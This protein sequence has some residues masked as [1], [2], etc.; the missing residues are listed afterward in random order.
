MKKDLFYRCLS[1]LAFFS[2]TLIFSY[3]KK[4]DPS[5]VF[6][7]QGN[8]GIE[9]GIVKT[10]D[11]ASVEIPPDALSTS[12]TISITYVTNNDI[13]INYGNKIYELKPDG[14]T[15]NDSII[16][17]LPFD[18]TYVDL[19]NNEDNYGIGIMVLQNNEWIKLKTNID[20]QNKIAY[21]KTN[22]FS[23]YLVFNPSKWSDYFIKN[24]NSESKVWDVPY[25]YQGAAEWCGYYS[26]S[27]AA[28]YAGYSIKGPQFAAKFN[29]PYDDG[30]TRL[31]NI[32][33]GLTLSQM[34]IS[35]EIAYPSWAN[36]TDLCGYIISILQTGNP[37]WLGIKDHDHAVII[38]G[39]NNTGFFVNDPS[40]HYLNQLPI[41]HPVNN[42]VLVPY[43]IFITSL[44]GPKNECTLT[45]T[46]SGSHSKKGITLNFQQGVSWLK[47]YNNS[48]NWIGKLFFDGTHNDDG[49]YLLNKITNEESFDGSDYVYICPN[50]GNSNLENSVDCNLNVLL[51]NKLK[52]GPIPLNI[53]AHTDY[54][55]ID[56]VTFQLSNL[57][58]GTHILT[59]VISSQNNSEVYDFW[60]FRINLANEFID[61]GQ[62]PNTPSLPNPGNR[63]S[64]VRT[65]TTLTWSCSDPDGD[66]LAYDVYF[67]TNENPLN[68]IISNSASTSI[69][70]SSLNQGV[71]YFWRVVARD[72]Q[73]NSTTGPVW[74]FTIGTT[75]VVDFTYSPNPVIAGQ[76]V[77]FTDRSSSN[78]TGWEWDFGDGSNTSN[79]QNPTHRF[80]SPGTYE[81]N[82][83][84]SNVFGWS[85]ASTRITV[86]ADVSVPVANFTA[87]QTTI[88]AGGTITFTDQSTNNPTSWSWNFDDGGNST[89]RNPF[90]TYSTAGTYTVTLTATNSAGSDIETNNIT[91]SERCIPLLISPENNAELDNSCTLNGSD[92]SD[93]ISWFFDWN[94]CAGATRYNLYVIGRDAIIPAI[95]IE[96]QSSE[97]SSFS[98]GS[99][100]GD[101][102]G[103]VHRIGWRWRVRAFVNGE[104]GEWSNER[105]FDVE[106]L[107]TD[108]QTETVTDIDG[109]V[110]NTVTIGTQI[111]MAENLATTRYSDGTS[112]PLVTENSTWGNLLNN[113]TVRAYCYYNNNTNG[114][115]DIFGALY[116]W[117]A[118][119]NGANSSSSNPS[120]VQGV[121]P[122]GWHLPSDAEWSELSDYLIINGY[123]Y[124]G[125]GTD[126]ANALAANQYWENSMTE[127]GETYVSIP[128][129]P[130]YDLNSNNSSGF[131]ALPSGRRL[132]TDGVF[133]NLGYQIELWTSTEVAS[134][135]SYVRTLGFY[136]PDLIRDGGMKSY[137]FSVRCIKD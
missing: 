15:F 38:A 125:S 67:G 109:N 1:I 13:V 93:N 35:T 122:L 133:D 47:I 50:I 114:E 34:G 83:R 66:P 129:T 64:G 115:K 22:H 29:A 98:T 74:S 113:N 10:N 43:N 103:D 36:A 100:I 111:W 73:G 62:P 82:L 110:Y 20:L 40:G 91:V 120:N 95:D 6:V 14:L 75:P 23:T 126:I 137:G 7:D 84:A 53:P 112:I 4:D 104:W 79:V 42:M 97:Y 92:I 18:N 28:K 116:T 2:L 127:E 81:V 19:S 30:M 16:I 72:N 99:Y 59:V 68:Q 52:I 132:D 85:V 77:Q 102:N 21:A 123:G 80:N 135:Y 46:S 32:L 48:E 101:L 5:P 128:G 55:N 108:C 3:C 39:F 106:P 45:I 119:M 51:D 121:C 37:V 61:N 11:G 70:R 118:A 58:K 71:T 69:P 63:E 57:T 12:K 89:S 76:T 131:F 105:T 136:L 117:A 33:K 25:Y 96:T 56:P 27:M 9:G 87:S 65:A 49:Y 17:S 41:E 54:H 44:S 90:H 134:T 86:N 8:I 31:D 24:K 60:N 124:E 130:G 94:D 26:L 88:Q 107:N 78:T